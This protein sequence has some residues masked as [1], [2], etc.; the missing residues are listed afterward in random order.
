MN[1]P[2]EQN[3]TDGLAIAVSQPPLLAS[4]AT[5]WSAILAGA[6]VVA[7]LSLILL[8]LGAGFGLSL[9]SP[10]AGGGVSA[11][12]FGV[13]TIL[14]VTVTQLVAAGMG[15]YLAGRLRVRW[16]GV[17]SD[18][19]YFRDTAHGFL[20]W[21]V[22]TLATATLLTSVI[23]SIVGQGVQVRD[24][25]AG[26]RP[27]TAAIA[28]SAD[29]TLE[30]G[31]AVENPDTDSGPIGYF[32]DS[33]FRQDT[34]WAAGASARTVGAS[35]SVAAAEPATPALRSEVARIFTNAISAETLPAEDVRYLGQMVARCTGLAQPDAEKRVT[36]IFERVRATL[37]DAETASRAAT[38]TARKATAYASLWLFISLLGGAFV[39]S[40]AAIYGGRQRDL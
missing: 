11:A 29:V 9:M 26:G 35:V 39:A 40:F 17:H 19:V 33:L 24:S 28:S 12:T 13:S 23:G 8:I 4:S 30:A 6:A 18:E 32:V 25:V 27:W 3:A 34:D 22:A 1:N 5:S 7:A 31:H 2:R 21:A 38:D 14:W 36:D 10:W 20:A 37:R 15:G 16:V